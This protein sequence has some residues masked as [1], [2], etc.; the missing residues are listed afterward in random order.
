M[1]VSSCSLCTE[2]SSVSLSKFFCACPLRTAFFLQSHWSHRSKS[3]WL[4]VIGVFKAHP[5]DG[6]LRSCGARCEVQTLDSSGRI[7]ELGGFLSI[8]WH[9][10]GVRFMTQVCLGLSYLF[11]CE[12]FLSHLM[13]RSHS[14]SGFPSGGIVPSVAVNLVLLWEKGSSAASHVTILVPPFQMSNFQEKDTRCTKK[15]E[16]WTIQMNKHNIQKVTLKK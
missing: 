12:Y 7:W 14:V 1:N 15:E 8:V 5:S 16:T 11:Q 9:M 6:S 10:L 13:C 3:H 2:P 4:S